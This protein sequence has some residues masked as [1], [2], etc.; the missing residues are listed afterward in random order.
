MALVIVATFC[1]L[2]N[3]QWHREIAESGWW[4]WTQRN[5]LSFHGLDD[6]IHADTMLFILGLTFFALDTSSN[7]RLTSAAHR[8]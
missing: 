3:S 6:L 5:L 1:G 8:S 4:L 2:A 7:S